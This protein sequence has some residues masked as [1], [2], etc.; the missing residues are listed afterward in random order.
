MPLIKELL[1]QC[2]RQLAE[3]FLFIEALLVK[4]VQIADASVLLRLKFIKIVP[5]IPEQ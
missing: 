5:G 2:P 1:F 4:K 3:V